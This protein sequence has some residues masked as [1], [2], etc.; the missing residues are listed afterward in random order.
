MKTFNVVVRLSS[1]KFLQV[2]LNWESNA[3]KIRSSK[4]FFEDQ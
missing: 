1:K 2:A 3:E 4:T